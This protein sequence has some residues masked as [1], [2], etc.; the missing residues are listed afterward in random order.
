MDFI[1]TIDNTTNT[2]NNEPLTKNPSSIRLRGFLA[3]LASI[4]ISLIVTMPFVM[5]LIYGILAKDLSLYSFGT[6]IVNYFSLL[7]PVALIFSIITSPFILI[8]TLIYL[9]LG[10]IVAPYFAKKYPERFFKNMVILGVI[11]FS[12]GLGLAAAIVNTMNY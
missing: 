6:Q 9:A 7:M 2:E 4:G 8:F 10:A 3:F 1:K 11:I 12:F 5:A